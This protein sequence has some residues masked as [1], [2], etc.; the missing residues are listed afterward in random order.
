MTSGGAAGVRIWAARIRGAG[1]A[2][3]PSRAAGS[4][5]RVGGG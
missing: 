1:A 2:D 5:G 4:G 3:S